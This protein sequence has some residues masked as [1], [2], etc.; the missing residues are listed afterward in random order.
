MLLIKKKREEGRVS[1][2]MRKE[3]REKQL[4]LYTMVRFASFYG[5]NG[6]K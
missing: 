2:K 4:H 5:N 6:K 3:K 1:S